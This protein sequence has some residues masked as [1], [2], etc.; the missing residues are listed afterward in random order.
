MEVCG[1]PVRSVE[2][3]WKSVPYVLA[4]QCCE[5]LEV[6]LGQLRLGHGGACV[7]TLLHII[8]IILILIIIVRVVIIIVI[9]QIVIVIIMVIVIILIITIIA[10]LLV[11]IVMLRTGHATHSC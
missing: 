8:I 5:V 4:A 1:S 3:L 11:I 7:I 6:L 2:S 9:V 10:I